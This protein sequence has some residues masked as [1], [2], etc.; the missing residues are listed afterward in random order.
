MLSLTIL[1]VM[2]L[3]PLFVLA[4]LMAIVA[5]AVG[6]TRS[7]ISVGLVAALL[8]TLVA[9]VSI[10]SLRWAESIQLPTRAG[11]TLLTVALEFIAIFVILKRAFKLSFGRT[12]APLGAL[13]AFSIAQ[14]PLVMLIIRPYVMTAM[15][16]SASSMVPTVNEGDHFIV[17]KLITPRRWDLIA[18]HNNNDTFCKRLIGLPGE[19]VKFVNGSIEI[20]GQLADVPPVLAGRCHAAPIGI[21]PHDARYHDGDA[22]TLGAAEYF[23]IGD[24]IDKSADSRSYG[25]SKGSS[26]IGVVDLI[27]WPADRIRIIR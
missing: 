9:L 11:V 5:R 4:W 26:L 17:N 23:V 19:S 13:I 14:Y 7:R 24:N 21:P 15:V 10:A 22:I 27:Y 1:L 8:S 16:L 20:D 6:S 18:Y 2:F 25:P 12:F 3:V